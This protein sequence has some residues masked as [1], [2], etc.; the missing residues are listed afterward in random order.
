MKINQIKSGIILSYI[1]MALNTLFGLVVTPFIIKNVGNG[2]YGVYKA[3]TALTSSIMVLDLGLGNTIQ[4][5]VAK[6]RSEKTEEKISGFFGM[7]ICQSFILCGLILCVSVFFFFFINNLYG[8]TFTDEQIFLAKQVFII[9]GINILLHV[10]SNVFHGLIT[11]FNKFFFGNGLSVLRLLLRISLGIVVIRLSHNILY[12]VILDLLLTIVFIIVEIIFVRFKL[13]IHIVFERWNK[14]VFLESGKYS[15]LMFL[16]SVA[17]QIM[18][19]L[20]NVVIGSISGPDFVTIY[21]IGL[22][23]FNMFSNISTAISGVMLPKVTEILHSDN[24]E[25][26][27]INLL[28]RV[29]RFQFLLL[30]ACIVGFVFL[31]KDFL[32]L[33]MGSGF[34]DVYLITL[35]LI[36]PSIF[37]YCLNVALSI[38]RARNLLGF[39]TIVLTASC[40]LNLIVTI[41]LVKYWSYIGAAVGTAVSYCFCSL[42]CMNIY[43]HKK[44]KL[45]LFKIYINILKGIWICLFVSGLALFV[46]SRFFYGSIISFVFGILLFCVVYGSCL[47][48]FGLNEEEKRK[49]P[50][51]GVLFKSKE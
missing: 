39:R 6:Y 7:M 25:D 41:V 17:S 38:L 29:G 37:E 8:K 26:R 49:I 45:P 40:V 10:V 36:V 13:G 3:I 48:L 30:S 2:D 9:S 31:G 32:M 15:V 50:F 4:R 11:G 22:L 43:Y 34:E 51:I 19:N 28:V 16:T 33:W 23:I 27:I 24:S 21:S 46:Y 47:I 18:S 44:L 14:Q 42:I 12:F 20:D 5:Y 1:L 35:I